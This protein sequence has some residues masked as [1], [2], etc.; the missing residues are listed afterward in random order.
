MKKFWMGVAAAAL[1]ATQTIGAHAEYKAEHR[2]GTMK[3]V[4][5]AAAGT[6]DPHINYTLQYWQIYQGLYDG[7]VAF[8]KAE[9]A[10]GFGLADLAGVLRWF[11]IAGDH[12]FV[13]QGFMA[14]AH[15]DR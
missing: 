5:H 7:L 2:G 13:A 1:L 8:K 6:L 15:H 4:A 10:E 11:A 14:D 12:A 9:G 3:I